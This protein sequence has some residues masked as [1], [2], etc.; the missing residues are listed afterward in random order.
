MWKMGESSFYF[1][2]GTD[3]HVSPGVNGASPSFVEYTND[4]AIAGQS[5]ASDDWQYLVYTWKWNGDSTGT[6]R[7]FIDGA[8]IPL[9]EDSVT[10]RID[11]NSNA[12][13]RIGQPNNNESYSYF[14]GLMDELEISAVARSADWIKL[15]YMNQR[16]GSVLVKQ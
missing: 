6:S 15:C 11:E 3:T 12:M 5:V 16:T 2:D 13:V 7:Y 14:K 10:V 4:Y 8:E 9:S 1:G